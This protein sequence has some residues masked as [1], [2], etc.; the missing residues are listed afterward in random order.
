MPKSY[1][2][3]YVVVFVA[4][5]CTLILEIVAG[6]ILAP[7]VGV[8]IYTWTSIIGVVLAGI[9]LGN[10]LGG[11]IADRWASRR[12]LGLLLALGGLSSL[13]I[14]PLIELV[15]GYS[16]PDGFPLVLKIVAMTTAIFFPPAF[17]LGMVSPVV[18]KLT[19]RD[20]TQTG[21]VV[22]RIYAFSTLGSILGT[23]LTGFLLIALLGTRMIVLGVGIVLLALAVLAG[24][25]LRG[26]KTSAVV[27]AAVLGVLYAGSSL[28]SFSSGCTRETDY[29]CIKV[30]PLEVSS[31]RTVQ[32]LVLDHLIHSYTDVDDPSYLRYGYIQ[33]YAEIAD[34]QARQHP[35]FRAL[36]I[37]GGGYTMPRYI[38]RFYPQAS[39]VV[40]EIDPG[41][42]EVAHQYMGLSPDTRVRTI[43][44]DGRL[45]I[46]QMRG[47]AIYDLVIGDAFN[48]LSV[49]YH[50]TTQEFSQQLKDVMGPD[51]FYLVN[52]IDKIEGGRFLPS[53]VRTLKTVFP[54]VYILSDGESWYSTRA[55]TYVVAASSTPL[56][57]ERLRQV[58]GQG[59]GGTVVTRAM[60]QERLEAWLASADS[61]LLTDDHA[62]V[63]NLLAPLFV[64]RGV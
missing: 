62:P 39:D 29:Y 13:S 14:L 41:V 11:V 46:G 40:L 21:G 18:V 23:F 22:G 2:A 45:A 63:D 37:G 31:Q 49:P 64:E 24:G 52:V 3:S 26:R 10:Y 61:L 16:Y 53:I 32:Q 55:S 17:I 1:W 38:E 20:L 6:R 35:A 44:A 54:Y 60:P 5:A 59:S 36:H 15:T 8:S 50:L 51:A 9:S 58:H 33:V 30:L 27:A 4:S 12:V 19:L 34:Y 56:D 47:Q 57:Q 28:Q 7:Y 25:L 42:T 48:D 43:N